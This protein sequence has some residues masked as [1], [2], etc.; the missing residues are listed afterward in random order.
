VTSK[1][2]E[3]HILTDATLLNSKD[4]QNF[5]SRFSGVWHR[6]VLWYDTI[7]GVWHR[8]VLR[9]NTTQKTSTWNIT[10]VKASQLA[11]IEPSIFFSLVIR[12]WYVSQ[13]LC[14]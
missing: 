14:A 12:N 7:S 9:Q 13:C 5:T 6:L 1:Q 11:C 3:H 4:I 10:A 8:L 2:I